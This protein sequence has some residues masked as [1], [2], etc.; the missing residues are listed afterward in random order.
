MHVEEMGYLNA[1]EPFHAH[2]E[3]EL[4]HINQSFGGNIAGS[5]ILH[6]EMR[7]I[8]SRFLSIGL[9]TLVLDM[10]HEREAGHLHGVDA[11]ERWQSYCRELADSAYRKTLYRRYPVLSKFL[12]EATENF[13]SFIKEFIQRLNDSEDDLSAFISADEPLRLEHVSLDGGDAHGHGR[14]VILFT[15]N[16]VRLVYKPRDLAVHAMFNDLVTACAEETPSF[17]DMRPTRVICR[18]GYAF[19]EFVEHEDCSSEGGIRRYYRRFGQ[20]LGLVWFLHGNDMHFENI[21]AGGEYPQIVDYETI[22]TGQVRLKSRHTDADTLVRDA[23]RN[24][25]TATALLPF[26]MAIDGE[27][28]TLEISALDPG[29][30]RVP[31]VMPVPVQLDT[32]EAHYEHRDEAFG[33]EGSVVRLNGETV[34][35][36]RYGEKILQGFDSSI[37]A[38]T[39]LGRERISHLLESRTLRV[40]VLL[41]ATN[42]YSR[43][44]EYIRHPHELDD[45]HK[46]ESILDHLHEY[47]FADKRL[48]DSEYRQ[49]LGGDI[50]MFTAWIDG[51]AVYDPDGNPVAD[52]LPRSPKECV[53]D[54]FDDLSSQANLQR[55]II[56]NSLHMPVPEARMAPPYRFNG[57]AVD[58]Y[59]SMV[60]DDLMHRAV[61]DTDTDTISWIACRRVEGHD[62]EVEY[63]PSTPAKDL[64]DGMSGAGLLLLET[65]QRADDERL[66][67][68]TRQCLKSVFEPSAGTDGMSSFLGSLSQVY[69]AMRM[70][71]SGVRTKESERFLRDYLRYIPQSV[72]RSIRELASSKD[73]DGTRTLDYL[74]GMC[75]AIAMHVRLYEALHDV[76][77]LTRTLPLAD[78]V[79]PVIERRWSDIP[80]DNGNDFPAGA[81]HGMEGMTVAFWMLHV[82]TGE[83]RYGDF[84]RRLWQHAA[85]RRSM[86]REH[87]DVKWCRGE[88][89]VLWAQNE[90]ESMNGLG[91]EPFFKDDA[92]PAYPDKADIGHLLESVQWNDDTVCHGRCGAIDTLVSLYNTRNDDWY[93]WRARKLLESMIR[94]APETRR[95]RL[96]RI[97]EF[98]DPSY[99]LGPV[100]VAYTMLRV[101]NPSIPSI[102][103]LEVA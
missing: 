71:R 75:G 1:F 95:P 35:P 6:E 100:G 21:I 96:G 18:D 103:A 65:S 45:M 58:E 80:A 25:L 50:P 32:D 2:V 85:E 74:T 78:A 33:K 30:Q 8:E 36:Y 24:S 93:L 98:V 102:L 60:V 52:A 87:S 56:R 41:R 49:M 54:R 73:T 22:I 28:H 92:T 55:S 61:T 91:N 13:L 79:V 53:L 68:F 77:L 16:G 57:N 12:T 81:A 20:L 66:A 47:P 67:M 38:I 46:V 48:S 23:I 3:E 9:K 27:G 11:H 26:H 97:P 86:Q 44:L 29:E 5:T 84:A 42:I 59:A 76:D 37:E 72:E 4:P 19:E 39:A 43:F 94:Q 14:T 69:I 34:D 17:L 51:C 88:V 89:G 62:Q 7:A 15:L 64:Y 90:L 101:Q 31:S 70:R 10:Y 83:S 82:S 40:R 99:F 63:T